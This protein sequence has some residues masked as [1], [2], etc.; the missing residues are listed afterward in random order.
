MGAKLNGLK[1]GAT[2]FLYYL[3]KKDAKA[4]SLK[5]THEEK[6]RNNLSNDVFYD[7]GVV[8][9]T[10]VLT[11]VATYSGILARQYLYHAFGL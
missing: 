6:L 1:Y 8:S 4:D 3:A 7:L 11:G 2:S 9:V 10:I 5:R